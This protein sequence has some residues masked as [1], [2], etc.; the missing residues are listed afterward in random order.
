MQLNETSSDLSSG[1]LLQRS[2][3][4]QSLPIYPGLDIAAEVWTAVDLGGDYYQFLEQSGTLAVAIADSSGKSVAGAIHA[5]LFKGQLDAYG[6]QGRLQNPASM[7]NSLNQLLC[8]SHID[9]AVALSYGAI[10]LVTYELHLGN[11]GIPGP[12]IYRADSNTC[13]EI[14]N[15]AIA[16]G[17]FDSA[18]YRAV[19]RSLNEGDIAIFFSDGL[20]EATNPLGEEFGRTRDNEDISPLRQTVIQLAQNSAVDI[21]EGLKTALDQFSE[22]D[23]PD[24]DVSI[25]IIKLNQKV[26]F[27]ELR[28]CPYLEALQAW[29]RSE[30]TDDSALLRGTRLAEAIAWAESQAELPRIDRSFLEASQRISEREQ[31]MSA[32]A[33]DADRLEKL[34]QELEKSLDAERRQRIVAEMGEINEKIVALT[35]SSEA[36][37]LSNNH[38]EAM[39]AGVIGGVQL[40]RLTTQVD[41]STLANLRANTQIRS[42]T[43]LEQVV[44]GIHE[45]NRL[46]GHGFWV[47]KVCYSR[48]GQYIA[49]ASSDRSIKI[50]DESGILLQTLVGHTNWV[51][52]VAFSPDGKLLVSGS[53]DNMLKLWK[54]NP[55][56][57]NF[58]EQPIA[59]LKGH[60][61][62]V[63]DVCFSNNGEMIASASED[64]TVRLW[65]N[66]GTAIRTLRG[67]HDRWVT[68]VAFHP[69]SKS[70][71]SG[72]A[73]RSL[74]IWNTLGV[75]VKHLRSHDSFVESVAY[76][77]NGLAIASGSRDRTVKIWGSDGVLIK[78]FY[79]HTDKVW[80]VAFSYDNHTIASSGFDREIRVWDIEQGLLHRFQG[81]GDVVHSVAFSPDGK[82]LASASRDTTVKLW[83]IGGTPLKTLMGHTD[84]VFSVAVSP[85]S[86]FLASA[87]KD[88]TVNLWNANG[89][90]EAVLEGHNDKVNCVTFSPDS[91][92]ILTASADTSIRMWKTDG[93]LINTISAHRAEIYKVV[94]RCDG[95]VF[96][97]CSAD[98]T[99]RVWS[100]D[101]KWLQ[102]LT[103]HSSEVYSIDF[104]P[105]GSMLAS[106][107]KDKLI[108]LWSWDG[109]LLGTLDGHSAEVYTVCFN[110]NGTGLASGSMDQSVKLWSIDG[111][112]IKTLNGHS[113]E[114]TSICF[115][116]DGKSIVSASEDSTIQFW[117]GEGT[118]LRTFNGHQGPVRSVCF[119]P[120][121]KTLISSGEDRKIIMWNLDL[122]NLLMRGCQWLQK[123]LRTNINV[124]A[125][126]KRTCL[127]GC[128]WLYKYLKSTSPT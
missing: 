127:G 22:R 77:P 34:S 121:G 31:L 104:S 40:K 119:S 73:D 42:I 5:A 9:D 112:L 126:D 53:R 92:T 97:T 88:K 8:K 86:K 84:E 114:V 72:S 44:Y 60:D 27:S 83:S 20:F 74:I 93:T 65:K 33:A 7:L 75:A 123:Y 29:Q 69:N 30:E 21:L 78:T 6:Q 128:G 11:A 16:L 91:S 18:A 1:R 100:S 81:H 23:I 110:P 79:G 36:L 105:D 46:E 38:I 37:Y 54:R 89:T 56:T 70:L 12:L 3:L 106:A 52:S 24:D 19:S 2:L 41:E 13:E 111:K 28:N 101:G 103:G 76:A 99:V 87:C 51:T 10:D 49:S 47:N 43:A 115:S 45:Y 55:D 50:W 57:G 62:P 15:P 85:N 17:R 113:A 14:V 80:S 109:T 116:P 67:G 117:S 48:D 71:V 108:N 25:V 90:L 96:A 125:E 4:P 26:H 68:C 107:S 102:T 66:D 118:L 59:T 63:L 58:E 64:T 35:I 124:S 94:Y 39:I 98:G 122:E 95:Q 61:G 82:N 32:R 120:N